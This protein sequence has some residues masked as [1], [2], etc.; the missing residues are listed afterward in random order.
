M[1][2]TFNA[3]VVHVRAK[4]VIYMLEDIRLA[5]MERIALKRG[6]IEKVDDEIFPRARERLEKER[7]DAKNCHPLSSENTVFEVGHKL[8]SLHVDN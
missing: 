1:A 4:H 3:Y 8:D 5:L 2:E 7:Q 6:H